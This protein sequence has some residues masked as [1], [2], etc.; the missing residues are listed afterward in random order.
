M[1]GELTV[2]STLGKGSTFTAHATVELIEEEFV[3]EINKP[4]TTEITSNSSS[5]VRSEPKTILVAE[6]NPVNR[7]LIEY[8][9]EI[10]GYKT[11]VAENGIEAVNV[12]KSKHVDLVLMDMQMPEMGGI[13]A[14]KIIRTLDGTHGKIPIVALTAHALNEHQDQCLE[15]GM[16]AFLV[17]PINRKKLLETLQHYLVER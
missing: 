4:I 5:A 2:E 16:N 10:A 8:L 12:V 13:E 17:K 1:G 11:V 6:D 14:T 3:E 15:A 7:K 9:L